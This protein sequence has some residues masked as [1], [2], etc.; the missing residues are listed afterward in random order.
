MRRVFLNPKIDA[1]GERHKQ[2][3]TGVRAAM[4]ILL[5]RGLWQS[6]LTGVEAL[7]PGSVS[8]GGWRNRL[9]TTSIASSSDYRLN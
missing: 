6:L 7:A 8:T 9:Y 4:T 5:F 2:T 3:K 1:D